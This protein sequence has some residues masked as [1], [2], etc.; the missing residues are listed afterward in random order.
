MQQTE[1]E[2]KYKMVITTALATLPHNTEH[3][4]KVEAVLR[5][6]F[7]VAMDV[8]ISHTIKE[9]DTVLL[10]SELPN[11]FPFTVV[12]ILEGESRGFAVIRRVVGNPRLVSIY[13][14][15]PCEQTKE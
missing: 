2:K 3:D 12:K 11:K 8:G 14:M 15:T 4:E 7:S 13:D 1:F 9:G 6:L 10:F 5:N